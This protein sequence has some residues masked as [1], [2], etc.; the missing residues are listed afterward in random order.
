MLNFLLF[1]LLNY[2]PEKLRHLI[3]ELNEH[4]KTSMYI[5]TFEVSKSKKFQRT[6]IR[7][8]KVRIFP[9]DHSFISSFIQSNYSPLIQRRMN[10]C[11]CRAV[12]CG[13]FGVDDW[14]VRFYCIIRGKI[15]KVSIMIGV[16]KIIRYWD[17]QSIEDNQILR[18]NVWR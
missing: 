17:Y 11:Y 6:L 18:I 9:F 4:E 7:S 12:I 13:Y 10:E 2:E 14:F 1:I 8:A 16:L 3:L 5:V 15:I